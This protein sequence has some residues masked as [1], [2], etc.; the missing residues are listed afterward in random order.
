MFL[1]EVCMTISLKLLGSDKGIEQQLVASLVDE[2]NA[3]LIAKSKS[4]ESQ[5]KQLIPIWI[6]SQPEMASLRA[7]GPNTLSAH[8]GLPVGTGDS[9]VDSIITSVAQSTVLEIKKVTKK[10]LGV[11]GVPVITISFQPATFQNLLSLGAGKYTSENGSAI[12][13]LE[14][15]FTLGDTPIVVG[16]EYLPGL[17][18]RSG[19]GIMVGGSLWR[20][21]PEFSG[22]LSNNFITRALDNRQK[23]IERIFR[24]VLN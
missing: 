24:R 7:S 14:W 4:L 21:P 22:T 3:V 2:V 12:P 8:F 1:G 5:I 20:V 9:A 17:G 23:D 11:K 15:L 6:G 18:G 10:R 13:W 19:G 16:Y